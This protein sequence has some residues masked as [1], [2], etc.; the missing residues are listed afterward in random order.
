MTKTEALLR[1]GKA[2]LESMSVTMRAAAPAFSAL[3]RRRKMMNFEARYAEVSRRFEL[4]RAAGTE[5]VADLKVGL[6]K[7]WDAFQSEIGW[8]P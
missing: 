3:V 2:R 8:K 6:E 4:L 1:Q 7:A 5:G